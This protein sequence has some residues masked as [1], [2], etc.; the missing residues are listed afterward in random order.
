MTPFHHGF[1]DELLKLA[2]AGKIAKGIASKAA[3]VPGWLLRH[4]RTSIYT[5]L[6]AP[7]AYAGA[8]AGVKTSPR[9]LAK[10][11]KPT[12]AYYIDYHKAMGIP[13]K[14]TPRQKFLESRYFSKYR[15]RR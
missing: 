7:A 14:R 1:S 5:L 4:P 9:V 6:T 11:G 10:P 2:I 12:P 13:K 15:E 8:K 3:N